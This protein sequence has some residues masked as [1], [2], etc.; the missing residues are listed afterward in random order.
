M[1]VLVALEQGGAR[2]EEREKLVREWW[3]FETGLR[4]GDAAKER[5]IT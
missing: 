4:S 1:Y 2:K 3:R 5:L